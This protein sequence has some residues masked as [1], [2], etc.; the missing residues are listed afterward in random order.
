MKHQHTD[1]YSTNDVPV[2]KRRTTKTETW[3]CTLHAFLNSIL[4]ETV[5]RRSGSFATQVA[6]RTGLGHETISC[7]PRKLNNIANPQSLHSP[8]YPLCSKQL[9]T[10]N[11]LLTSTFLDIIKETTANHKLWKLFQEVCKYMS[12]TIFLPRL[13]LS[14]FSEMV[15]Y[16]MKRLYTINLLNAHTVTPYVLK[17]NKIVSGFSQHNVIL[18]T[19]CFGHLTIIRPYLQNLE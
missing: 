15:H 9:F 14:T 7:R 16:C 13:Q 3:R 5:S 10:E 17:D 11:S 1:L 12:Y 19:I 2:L 18:M 4:N 6:A 8:S